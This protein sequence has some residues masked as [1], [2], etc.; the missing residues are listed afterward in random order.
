VPL[1]QNP[2]AICQSAEEDA[3]VD[4]DVN[5]ENQEEEE[6]LP[7]ALP[8]AEEEDPSDDQENEDPAPAP[9]ALHDY[10]PRMQPEPEMQAASAPT[11]AAPHNPNGRMPGQLPI[12]TYC[13]KITISLMVYELMLGL[14]QLKQQW[15]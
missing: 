2:T 10:V 14:D 12:A 4:I 1:P 6:H 5:I 3:N 8:N 11:Q 13:K 7:Q 15:K 9:T